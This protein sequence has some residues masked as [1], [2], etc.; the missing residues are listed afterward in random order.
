MTTTTSYGSW[1]NHGDRSALTVAQ[2]VQEAFGSWGSDGFDVEAIVREYRAAIN[3]AL[4]EGV[5][6]VGNEFI[7]PWPQMDID[8]TACV[9]SVDLWPIIQRHAVE[10]RAE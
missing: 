1:N 7:G 3:R 5:H 4:P 9:K 6:L 8:I 2:T 10:E